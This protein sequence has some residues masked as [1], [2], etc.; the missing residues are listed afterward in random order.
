M[1]IFILVLLVLS[2]IIAGCNDRKIMD[3]LQEKYGGEI[4]SVRSSSNSTTYEQDFILCEEEKLKGDCKSRDFRD[5]DSL[6]QVSRSQGKRIFK[7]PDKYLLISELFDKRL[8]IID[9]ESFTLCIGSIRY[10]WDSDNPDIVIKMEGTNCD[11]TLVT[12]FNPIWLDEQ[13]LKNEGF[14]TRKTLLGDREVFE[15]YKI[16]KHRK[17]DRETTESF[18]FDS[19]DLTPIKE[20]STSV[21]L[22]DLLIDGKE[23]SHIGLKKDESST[24]LS[25]NDIEDSEFILPEEIANL[26]VCSYT[27][28]EYKEYFYKI[29]EM[30][31]RLLSKTMETQQKVSEEEFNDYENLRIQIPPA[32]C[33]G[34]QPRSYQEYLDATS[35]SWQA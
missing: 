33:L 17:G 28:D 11:T 16:E 26:E 20:I 4:D 7:D 10:N 6:E 5:F 25:I 14:K 24:K 18:Y 9:K 3:A 29:K 34:E 1:K 31:D 2:L 32:R 27:M 15:V 13:A 23:V 30:R 19:Q 22:F 12:N 35:W 8:G 21:R